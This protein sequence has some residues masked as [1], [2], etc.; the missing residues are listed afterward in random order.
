MKKK[1]S[2]KDIRLKI[3]NALSRREHS[4]KEIYL[5]FINLVDSKNN[6]LEEI[7]K[8]K[9]EG[10][11]SN[12]RY[13]EAYIRSRFHSGFGPVRIKY[14]L[15]KKGVIETTIIK[16]FQETDLDWD[17]KL[18]SEFKKKYESNEVKNLNINKI[19][20]FFLYRGF[21][22]EKISKLIKSN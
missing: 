18:K 22:L 6:L 13:A 14:E 17:D 12:Q 4:E 10:L 9:E 7:V 19:S 21:D 2:T 20:K 3:M 1:I 16:A 11:I 15:G 8:L 5:K